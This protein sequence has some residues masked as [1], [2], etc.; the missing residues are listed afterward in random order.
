MGTQVVLTLSD[1]LY[2]RAKRWA[3]RTRRDVPQTLTDALEIV[4]TPEQ[5]SP[6]PDPSVTTISDI[7]V[8]ALAQAQMARQQGERLDYLLAKQREEI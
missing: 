1:D 3:S 5:E 2:E 6:E 8:M 7:E 4:L